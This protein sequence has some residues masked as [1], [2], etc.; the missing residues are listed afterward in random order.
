M[1]V[2]GQCFSCVEETYMIL[3]SV[4]V[5]PWGKSGNPSVYLPPPLLSKSYIFQALPLSHYMIKTSFFY[6]EV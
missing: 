4:T 6:I 1:D 2:E 3:H 5:S